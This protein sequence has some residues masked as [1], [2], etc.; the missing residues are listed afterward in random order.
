MTANGWPSRCERTE[1]GCCRTNRV[2]GEICRRVFARN[3]TTGAAMIIDLLGGIRVQFE[4]TVQRVGGRWR[5]GRELD[6]DHRQCSPQRRCERI[7]ARRPGASTC[8]R[9]ELVSPGPALVEGRASRIDS[10]GPSKRTS[11]SLRPQTP[12]PCQASP[13]QE[14]KPSGVTGSGIRILSK[15]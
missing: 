11:P 8:W 6:D 12:T 5:A 14:V 4:A 10:D 9:D 13:G 3:C 15:G 7:L 1:N 2:A